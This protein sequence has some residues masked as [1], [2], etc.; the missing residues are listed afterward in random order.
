V[1]AFSSLRHAAVHLPAT[2]AGELKVW[3]HRVRP[4]GDAQGLPAVLDVHTGAA[5]TRLDLKPPGGHVLL[6]HNGE[7]CWLDITLAK[8]GG[9]P[10]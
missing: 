6:P 10:P 1:P 2:R 9:N 5:T 3:V 7:A 8:P 4:D